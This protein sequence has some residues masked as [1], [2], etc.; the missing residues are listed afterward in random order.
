MVTEAPGSSSARRIVKFGVFEL[1]LLS[2]ELRR[3]G[4]RVS[5]PEQPFRILS[6]LIEHRGELVTRA[7]LRARLWP[8]DTFVDFEHGLNAA[9][10]RLRSTLGDSADHPR[11]IE[12]VPRHGYRFIG[13]I[14]GEPVVDRA[15]SDGAPTG[16]LGSRRRL[17]AAAAAGLLMLALA[18]WIGMRWWSGSV[19]HSTA[20]EAPRQLTRLT[21][22][23]GL[24]TDPAF[25][26]DG[27]SIAYASNRSGNFDIWLL[28]LADGSSVR[29]T[30][31]PADD[32]QPNWS[33]DGR[34]IAFR[35]ERDGGGIFLLSPA[36]GHVR[37]FTDMGYLP[38]WS[39]DGSTLAFT[40]TATSGVEEY[41][42]LAAAEDARTTRITLPTV[43]G[44]GFA[45][46]GGWHPS[47]RLVFLHGAGP[48]LGLAALESGSS[49][50]TPR[51]I[52]AAVRERFV[53]L[54]LQVE[55]GQPLALSADGRALH[56]VAD[57]NGVKDIWRLTLDPST[58][59]VVEGPERMTISPGSN[60]MPAISPTGRRIAFSTS[61]QSLR[62]WLFELGAGGRIATQRP[63]ALT[64]DGLDVMQSA[65]SPDGSRLAFLARRTGA[66]DEVSLMV[67]P[68]SDPVRT[69]TLRTVNPNEGS[70]YAPRWAPDGTRIAYSHR[71]RGVGNPPTFTSSIRLVDVSSREESAVTS[72]WTSRVA[73]VENP[74]GWSADGRW[75]LASGD[76]YAKRGFGLVR[77]P[78]SGAPHAER[79]ARPIVSS[80]THGFWQAGESPDGRWICVNKTTL[81]DA[82]SSSLQIIPAQ[83]GE[84]RALLEW[85][86]WD[87]KPRWSAD[88]RIIYFLSRRGSSFNVWGVEFDSGLGRARG[89]PFQV[90]NLQG[91]GVRIG[92]LDRI[93]DVDIAL[94]GNSL[95]VPVQTPSGGIWLLE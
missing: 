58:L 11:Y 92:G 10:K 36:D 52:D 79:A 73:M 9:I 23:P 22:D 28:R 34:S 49:D 48:Q 4:L 62:L 38:R 66:R 18:G 75:L 33:P 29:L 13:P 63:D 35:S 56:F 81:R 94:A 82:V 64:A 95:A 6:L 7:E 21:F 69:D 65:L 46:A 27:E 90:T 55:S 43:E 87:D 17:G 84:P 41:Y 45:I 12:T 83:G 42:Y 8:A 25:S 67:A 74:W 77:L 19:P 14:G 89:T 24:Q 20:R 78:L 5:L 76:R 44:R 3:S 16:R 57:A 93:G 1:D 60:L 31:D 40:A 72:P 50:L 15:V 70:I 71:R 61:S 86:S 80:S 51:R 30:S 26:P 91:R 54:S 53:A 59:D 85:S 32:V 2:G 88:G 47:G 68:L 39:P 37:R